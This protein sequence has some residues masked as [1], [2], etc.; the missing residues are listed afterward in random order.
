MNRVD[1]KWSNWQYFLSYRSTWCTFPNK[2]FIYINVCTRNH[3]IW[4]SVTNGIAWQRYAYGCM[5]LQRALL[6][7]HNFIA[8]FVIQL[9]QRIQYCAVLSWTFV[10]IFATHLYHSVNAFI[11]LFNHIRQ[12]FASEE[13]H[14]LT[15]I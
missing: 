4:T 13:T 14:T 6:K 2:S 15:H 10:G 1:G 7:P 8:S 11:A 5:V 9:H 3:L 12:S